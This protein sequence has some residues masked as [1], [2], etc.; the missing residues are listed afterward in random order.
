MIVDYTKE[1]ASYYPFHKAQSII[2]AQGKGKNFLALIKLSEPFKRFDGK[3]GRYLLEYRE[4]SETCENSSDEAITCVSYSENTYWMN[5]E[6][7]GL[8]KE[9]KEKGASS[10]EINLFEHFELF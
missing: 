1:F 9:I 2:A 4:L 5:K 7:K 6:I 3:Y 10:D 8:L